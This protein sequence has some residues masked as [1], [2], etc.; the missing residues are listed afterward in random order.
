MCKSKRTAI[1]HNAKS[2]V[3]GD[4]FERIEI[5]LRFGKCQQIENEKERKMKK[6]EKKR[7]FDGVS[8]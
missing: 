5:G 3:N 4:L 7:M 8:A 2:D 6:I 1:Q